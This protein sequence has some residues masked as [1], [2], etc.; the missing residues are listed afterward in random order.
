MIYKFRII[1]DESKEFARELLIEGEQTFL[2]FNQCLQQNLGYD[3]KQL[4]S[5]FLTN[6]LWE[7]QLQITLIDMLDEEGGNCI[8]MD[9]AKIETHL[10]K[11][12]QRMIYVFDF[13]SE[14]S[15]FIELTEVLDIS[16]RKNL[17]KIIFSKGDPPQ[18]IEL[19]LD[20]LSF[21]KG[22]AEADFSIESYDDITDPNLEYFDT[23]DFPD[24]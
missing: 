15:F 1:S 8:T 7:K 12:G 11:K 3:P 23:E 6:A 10:S 13:F 19:A 9:Q 2:D 17:P 5:F 20:D 14:R 18:Q 22:S 16:E 21:T 4:A 24:D